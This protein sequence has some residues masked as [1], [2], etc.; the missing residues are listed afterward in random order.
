MSLGAALEK[1]MT[2][3]PALDPEDKQTRVLLFHASE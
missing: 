1:M 3:V 2:V